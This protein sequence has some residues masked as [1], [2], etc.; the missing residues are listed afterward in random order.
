MKK[1]T[2]AER[3]ERMNRICDLFIRISEY[4]VP[5]VVS[6][7]AAVFLTIKALGI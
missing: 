7:V 4:I 5:V 3:Q 1:R 6:A 2:I